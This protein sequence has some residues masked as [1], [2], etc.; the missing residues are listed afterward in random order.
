[1]HWSLKEFKEA[2][3]NP[4]AVVNG[5]SSREPILIEAKVGTLVILSAAGS[6]DP[7][8]DKIHYNWFYYPEAASAISKAASLKEIIGRRGED[9]LDIL[10]KVRIE[11]G[12]KEEAKV[13]PQASGQAH[14]ILVVEDE[15]EPALTAYRRVI[16]QIQE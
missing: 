7:D 12:S 14:V 3:H 2:N 1:M 13:I 16:F 11:G 8:G 5:D 4:V 10:P 9:E 6:T 15:G